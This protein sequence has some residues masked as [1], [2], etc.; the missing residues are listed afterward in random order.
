MKI[1]LSQLFGKPSDDGHRGQRTRRAAY[2]WPDAI[3][4]R[5]WRAATPPATRQAEPA[6]QQKDELDDLIDELDELDL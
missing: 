2:A 3:R 5:R 6:V 1:D 4:V